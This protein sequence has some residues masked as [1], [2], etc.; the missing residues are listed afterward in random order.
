MPNPNIMEAIYGPELFSVLNE[1]E[2]V[3]PPTT[4]LPTQSLSSVMYEAGQRS[5]VDWL[6]KR[7]QE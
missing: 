3:F 2:E 7:L 6:N 4:P 1:L 5:V